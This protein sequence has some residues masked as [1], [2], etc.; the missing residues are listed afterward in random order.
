MEIRGLERKRIL[1]FYFAA[2]RLNR[3]L[4][5]C[6]DIVALDYGCEESGMEKILALIEKK[7]ELTKLWNFLDKHLVG[8]SDE[9]VEALR[10][11]AFLRYGIGREDEEWRKLFFRTAA[12]F[13]RRIQGLN[14]FEKALNIVDEYYC[15]L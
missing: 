7:S 13:M 15:L 10:H 6:I 9:E 2:D 3:A 11:Y 14:R 4:N 8:F 12:R 1:R 5:N